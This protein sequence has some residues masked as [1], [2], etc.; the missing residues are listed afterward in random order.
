MPVRKSGWAFLYPETRP[1]GARKERDQREQEKN[2]TN[3][4]RE[5]RDQREQEKK[6]IEGSKKTKSRSDQTQRHVNDIPELRPTGAVHSAVF[7]E[8]WG[9]V[10]EGA[11]NFFFP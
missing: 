6:A 11:E 4:S 9:R 3:G 5:N 2:A 1:A 7:L 8:K 10:R